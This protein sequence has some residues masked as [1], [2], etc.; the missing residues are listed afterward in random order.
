MKTKQQPKETP[1]EWGGVD[2][3]GPGGLARTTVEDGD[4]SIYFFARSG[5]ADL[6]VWKVT[7]SSATP[8]AVTVSVSL[9]A[10]RLAAGRAK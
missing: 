7:V 4:T 8:A 10:K 2:Y 9:Q 6:L 1:N 3:R 5:A